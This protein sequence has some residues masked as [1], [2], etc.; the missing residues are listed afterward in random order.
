M[1]DLMLIGDMIMLR[2]KINDMLGLN[3]SEK[4]QRIDF[5]CADFYILHKLLKNKDEIFNSFK[6]SLFEELIENFL[7]SYA[8]IPMSKFISIRLGLS[9]KK[10]I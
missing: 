8:Q 1:E 10:W 3:G 4:L 9:A 2:V 5:I 6:K 7:Q